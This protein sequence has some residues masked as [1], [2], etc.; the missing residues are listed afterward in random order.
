MGQEDLRFRGFERFLLLNT[1]LL[2]GGLIF[3]LFKN[4]YTIQRKK[5]LSEN[6]IFIPLLRF[7]LK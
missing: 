6:N 2:F 1:A 4:H 3:D 5:Y 7:L